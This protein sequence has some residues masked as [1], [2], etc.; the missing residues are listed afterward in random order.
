MSKRWRKRSQPTIRKFR[1]KTPKIQSK[2]LE[3]SYG[4]TTAIINK[5]CGQE[6]QKGKQIWWNEFRTKNNWNRA[7]IKFPEENSQFKSWS[8]KD[9]GSNIVAKMQFVKWSW[10]NSYKIDSKRIGQPK[11]A[12]RTISCFLMHINR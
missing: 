5:S 10:N 11:C 7:F 4:V 2:S 9:N 6:G 1:G 3:R 12:M 8:Q